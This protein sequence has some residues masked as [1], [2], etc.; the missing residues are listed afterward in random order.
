VERL[1]LFEQGG[2][3]PSDVANQVQLPFCDET[4]T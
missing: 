4:D 1:A 3:A 2:M